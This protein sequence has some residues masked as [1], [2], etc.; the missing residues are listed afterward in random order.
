MANPLVDMGTRMCMQKRL[1]LLY[2]LSCIGVC[3][4]NEMI[5]Q[6]IIEEYLDVIQRSRIRVRCMTRA[7][8]GVKS[9]GVGPISFSPKMVVQNLA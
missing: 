5:N 9:K 7:G 1:M 4:I 2:P 6:I 3:F 8:F